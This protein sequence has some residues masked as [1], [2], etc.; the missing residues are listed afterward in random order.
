VLLCALAVPLLLFG[1]IAAAW[2]WET[3]DDDDQVRRNIEVAGVNVGGMSRAAAQDEIDDLA[4]DMPSSPVSIG[5]DEFTIQTTAADLGV[6]VDADTTLDEV[7]AAGRG[8][9]GP[10]APVRWLQSWFNPRT[11][12][13]AL[14]VDRSQA[15][16]TIEALEGDRRTQPVE[17]SL[18]PTQE[19][20]TFVAGSD[21]TAIDVEDVIRKLPGASDDVGQA[22]EVATERVVSP[23]ELDDAQV[24]ALA[25]TAQELTTGTLVVT[26]D[27]EEDEIDRTQLRPGLQL[28]TS[29]EGPGLTLDRDYV[30][31]ALVVTLPP[32]ANPTG[33]SFT[34]A[35]GQ[36]VPVAGAD[37]AIC[38][39]DDAPD[40]IV[41]AVLT[42]AD[43]TELGGRT[44]TAAE[45]VEWASTLGVSEVVGE[46]TTNHAA[47]QPRVANIHRMAD[48]TRGVLIPPGGTF[49]VNDHVGRRTREKGYVADGAI[50]N[51]EFVQEVG[52]GVSQYATTLF[53]AAFFGGMDISEYKMHSIYIS[54]YPYARE[55]TLGFPSIDIEVH[56][57]SPYGVVVWPTYTNRSITVQLWSTQWAS[58]AQT[59]QS[60]SSGCGAVRTTRTR[61]YVDG[62]VDQQNY[63]ANY[64][65]DP[66]DH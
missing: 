2:F 49:S 22:I 28:T 30:V 26:F 29:G 46:F 15:G 19:A 42:G 41:D 55:A 1:F 24:E 21:G 48:M 65:C 53:N 7:M 35:D 57:P 62:R 27:G 3:R 45:G 25:A 37:A 23:P 51:G 8:D 5:T 38:C 11:V 54:R 56:N 66:P 20:V 18:A 16:G 12:S 64:D 32:P 52:G 43:A 61:T 47:G 10:L 34:I 60:K 31:Q 59:S 39:D 9:R 36:M 63:R 14:D 17:P 6:E 40:K 4:R 33:V 50:S 13:V 44:T 58:G